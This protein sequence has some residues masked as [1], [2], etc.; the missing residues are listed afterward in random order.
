MILPGMPSSAR[1]LIDEVAFTSEERL[2]EDSQ[3]GQGGT[4]PSPA[5]GLLLAGQSAAD[6]A[7]LA[8]CTSLTNNIY[9]VRNKYQYAKSC[10]VQQAHMHSVPTTACASCVGAAIMLCTA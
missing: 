7:P 1:E 8:P 4:G 5:S 10:R 9:N 3:G 2:E 6:E